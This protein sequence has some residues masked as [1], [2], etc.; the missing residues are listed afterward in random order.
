MAIKE[1][2]KLKEKLRKEIEKEIREQW[3]QEMKARRKWVKSQDYL[4]SEYPKPV[5]AKLTEFYKGGGSKTFPVEEIS[6]EIIVL[7]DKRELYTGVEPQLERVQGKFGWRGERR[8]Y[9]EFGM[10]FTFNPTKGGDER[11]FST[12]KKKS[13]KVED[14]SQSFQYD[15]SD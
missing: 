6:S 14:S 15:A 9:C 7:P 8:H 1:D 11:I 10:P 5:R 12:E 3:K 13:F 4:P 2:V